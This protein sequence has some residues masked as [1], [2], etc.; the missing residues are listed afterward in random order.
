MRPAA[1]RSS[2]YASPRRRAGGA[3]RAALAVVALLG[4]WMLAAAVYQAA[5][6]APG[7]PI[8]GHPSSQSAAHQD[9]LQAPSL[10]GQT[11]DAARQTAAAARVTVAIAS[12]RQDPSA[13]AGTILTQD[14][15]PETSLAP[16][17]VI[18]VVVSQ[19]SGV[20]PDLRG[21]SLDEA[22]KRLAAAGLA[23]GGAQQAFDG[24]VAP[25]MIVSESPVP[26]THLAPHS[27]VELVVSQGPN[28]AATPEQQSNQ[29]E[30][31][32]AAAQ[33]AVTTVPAANPA[34]SPQIVPV[35]AAS[36]ATALPSAVVPNVTGVPFSQAEAQLRAARLRVGQVNYTHT[37]DT[38][39]GVVIYQS[40]V[41]GTEAGAN[42]V[43][44]L[45]VNQAP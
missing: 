8:A 2:A 27:T 15:S 11:L 36:T 23:L 30:P 16:G 29:A 21:V 25:G 4:L 24:S 43:V 22:T 39:A 40:R 20:V 32:S 37:T 5:R 6:T 18:H 31:G 1:A 33:P 41:A 44:D 14:P 7:S 28:N 9:A 42:A 19:G 17:A 3:P 38:P 26:S 10:V 12:G 35:V 13:P 45:T 34:A